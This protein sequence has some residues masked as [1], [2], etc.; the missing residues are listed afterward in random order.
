MARMRSKRHAPL[1]ED[2]MLNEQRKTE[3][4]IFDHNTMRV[5]GKLFSKG[6]VSKLDYL[7][8]RGKEA[9][10]YLA[11]VGNS[12]IVE[13]EQLIALKFFRVD[14]TTFFNIKD[15]ILGDPRFERQ[16]GRGRYSIIKTWCKK[17]FGN[18]SI[19]IQAGVHA[20]KPYIY[21]ENILGMQFLG[22]KENIAPK[23]LDTEL[24]NPG[25][26]LNHIIKDVGRLF[27]YGL[28]H[29]DLSE[30]NILMHNGLPYMI[31][32]GQAISIKHPRAQEFLKRDLANLLKFFR[33]RYKI[34]K[35]IEEC[36]NK[37]VSNNVRKV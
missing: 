11:E 25:A 28:V 18:L 33:K 31:D 34:E 7:I 22:D 4:G 14:S 19:A 26:I 16:I 8:A 27:S 32:F 21:S 36:Y 17:E 23:L 20:P 12:E 1:R 6:I 9:D 5:L 3:Q 2:F 10:I 30:Y 15:Y 29:T 35:S 13:G 37:V 24:E